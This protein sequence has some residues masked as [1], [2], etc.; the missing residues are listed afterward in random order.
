MVLTLK[1]PL[2]VPRNTVPRKIK[3]DDLKELAYEV[4]ERLFIFV[5]IN[6]HKSD[7]SPRA[8]IVSTWQRTM[9]D[10]SQR[11]ARWRSHCDREA[12]HQHARLCLQVSSSAG[13]VFYE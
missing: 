8:D 9:H 10:R 11:H 2:V 7:F 13:I 4:R 3:I 6:V 12:P 1:N 5:Q